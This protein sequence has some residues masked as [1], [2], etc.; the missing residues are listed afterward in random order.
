MVNLIKI[1]RYSSKPSHCRLMDKINE[2]LVSRIDKYNLI[3]CMHIALL[4]I[5]LQ[6]F[7]EELTLKII[8]RMNDNIERVR[9]KELDRM[10]LVIALYDITTESGIEIEFMKKVLKELKVRVK[11]IVNHPRC[12]TSTIHYMSMK[13][14][15]DLELISAALKENFL[16]FAYGE[17]DLEKKDSEIIFYF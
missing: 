1:L 17:I 13:G 5:N 7:N 14:I 8:Q 3:T 4:G 10:T 9:L 11:E 6:N 2:V 16:Q 12:Y 15:Y